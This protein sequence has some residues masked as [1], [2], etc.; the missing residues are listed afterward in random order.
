MQSKIIIGIS[1]GIFT[2]VIFVAGFLSATYLNMTSGYAS[3]TKEH[4]DNGRF[5]LYALKSLEEGDI[6]QARQSLRGHISTKV[7]LA[8]VASLPPT[9][10]REKALVEDFYKEVI[11]YFDSQGGFN[12]TMQVMENGQWVTKPSPAMRILEDYAANSEK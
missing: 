9:S 5:M 3:Y 10:A 12:E 7:L 8:D 6:E 11:D 1:G 2:I 4:I